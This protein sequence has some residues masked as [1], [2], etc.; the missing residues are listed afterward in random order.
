[1]VPW[2]AFGHTMPFFELSKALAQKGITATIDIPLEKVHYLKK[3][4]DGLRAPFEDLV[5][6]VPPV[7]DF[8]TYWAT[9]IASKYGFSIIGR[10]RRTELLYPK[11]VAFPSTVA[12]RRHEAQAYIQHALT[13]LHNESGIS[14]MCRI[15]SVLEGCR[16]VA[17][18]TCKEFNGD[19][20]DLLEKLY[21]KSIFHLGFLPPS[22]TEREGNGNNW[23]DENK[24]STTFEWLDAQPLRSVVFV[25]FGRSKG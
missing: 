2:L 1:M 19:Y 6:K 11:G 17:L 16:A 13:N 22:Q 23:I 5:A 7:V 9:S 15:Q 20:I 8:A 10:L 25:G 12:F 3:A 4:Y 21:G 18:R 14:D 24:W